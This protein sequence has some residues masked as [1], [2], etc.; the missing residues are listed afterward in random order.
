MP[1][2]QGRWSGCGREPL[3][4][5]FALRRRLVYAT[6]LTGAE[7]GRRVDVVPVP[8]HNGRT[9]G[10]NIKTKMIKRPLYGRAGF[11]LLRNRVL[12]G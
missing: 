8:H 10:V 6:V 3:G 11:I 12:L 7:T 4:I 5:D 1:R 2:A 9:E